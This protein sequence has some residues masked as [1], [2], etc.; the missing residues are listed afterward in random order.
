MDM[1]EKVARAICQDLWEKGLINMAEKPSAFL[2]PAKLTAEKAIAAYKDALKEKGL[3][4]VPRE[5]T[6][7]MV[8]EGVNAY[9]MNPDTPDEEVESIYHAM[10]DAAP[11]TTP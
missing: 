4:I 10:V 3:V 6:E 5:L 8:Y 11:K 9:G 7:E 1:V 2:I